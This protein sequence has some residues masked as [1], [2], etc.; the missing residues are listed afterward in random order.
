[1]ADNVGYTPGTG[2]TVAADD[3]GGVLYQR[4]KIGIGDDGT[5]IDVSATNPL[6]VSGTV[7]ANTGLTQPLTD[8]QLRASAVPVSGTVT[9]N[10]GLTQPLTDAQLRAT[11][12]PVTIQ[13]GAS[14]TVDTSD[15]RNLSAA[16]VNLLESPRGYD[17]TLQR[18]RGTVIIESG[19]VTTV[20]SVSTVST[21]STVTTVTTVSTVSSIVDQTNIGG[22]SARIGQI[23]MNNNAWA[24]VVRARI[25]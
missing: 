12:V 9:A 4:V 14:I 25:S 19:T 18:Q 3:I 16:T 13:G 22:V 20:S 10:T 11:A 23:S 7:T 15:L 8:T 1:M 24:S 21:V 2:A 6:P 17:K 5:A